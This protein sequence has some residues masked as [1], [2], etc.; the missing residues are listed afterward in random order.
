MSSL[1][2]QCRPLLELSTI[3][4]SLRH[5]METRVVMLSQSS[6]NNVDASQWEMPIVQ[7]GRIERRRITSTEIV[8]G[9]ETGNWTMKGIASWRGREG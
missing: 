9:V 7:E 5:I 2:R 6:K 1:N 4:N 3:R 8:M